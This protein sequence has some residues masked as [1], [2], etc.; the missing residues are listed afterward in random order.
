MA[1]EGQGIGMLWHGVARRGLCEVLA[2]DSTGLAVGGVGLAWRRSGGGI[3]WAWHGR[4]I[5]EDGKAE[6]SIGIAWATL[7]KGL[8]TQRKRSGL[9]RVLG[10]MAAAP[11]RCHLSRLDIRS[12]VDFLRRRFG[13]N[14]KDP[15]ISPDHNEATQFGF[16]DSDVLPVQRGITEDRL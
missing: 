11:W 1:L 8:G 14:R 2:P 5:G 13:A 7:R 3:A 4:G 12:M 16:V 10:S 9:A 15:G 6:A